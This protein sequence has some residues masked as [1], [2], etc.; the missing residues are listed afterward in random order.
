MVRH[1]HERF[2]GKGYPDGLAG[3]QIPW[4]AR[5]LSLAESFTTI[6]EPESGEET[7]YLG[8]SIIAVADSYDAI[9]TDRPYRKALTI[10]E[11][12]LE[13]QKQRGQ[14]FDPCVVDAFLHLVRRNGNDIPINSGV[15]APIVPE[16]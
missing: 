11:A 8:A 10:E 16:L 4:G 2:D 6:S 7:L 15:G 14:Q 1:H 3:D 13:L 5:I 9:T 12:C